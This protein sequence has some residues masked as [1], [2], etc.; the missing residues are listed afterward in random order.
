ME[1]KR[2][3]S[4]VLSVLEKVAIV[5]MKVI[6]VFVLIGQFLLGAFFAA[7]FLLENVLRVAISRGHV[8]VTSIIIA[9][10]VAII[11]VCYSVACFWGITRLLGLKNWKLK[12]IIIWSLILMVVSA[13]VCAG[14]LLMLLSINS[15]VNYA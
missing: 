3:S 13:V 4:V 5:V 10:V 12:K 14:L 1:I 6:G 7:C 11:G 2:I 15:G 8:S 9:I